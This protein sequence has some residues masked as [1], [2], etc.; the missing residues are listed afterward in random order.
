MEGR[1][2]NASQFEG[3]NALQKRIEEL[4]KE[5]DRASEERDERCRQ[6]EDAQTELLKEHGSALSEMK[7]TLALLVSQTKDLPTA[8]DKINTRLTGV[9]KWKVYIAGIITAFT[10][11]GVVIGWVVS[12]VSPH[13]L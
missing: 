8:F 6:Q 7:V 9:E 4:T 1:N 3:V 10:A 2:T 13:R 11:I 5:R 12:L